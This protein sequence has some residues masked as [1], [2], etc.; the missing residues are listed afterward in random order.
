MKTRVQLLQNRSIEFPMLQ[1]LRNAMDANTKQASVFN[2]Q[3]SAGRKNSKYQE[4]E[5]SNSSLSFQFISFGDPGNLLNLSGL[6]YHLYNEKLNQ[7][8]C[9]MFPNYNSI[10]SITACFPILKFSIRDLL[11]IKQKHQDPSKVTNPYWGQNELLGQII[12]LCTVHVEGFK[13][14]GNAELLN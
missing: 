5:Y 12:R 6:Y 7:R 14:Q 2:R 3:Q 4:S 13:Y 10:I 9:Q 1:E 11:Q 8:I